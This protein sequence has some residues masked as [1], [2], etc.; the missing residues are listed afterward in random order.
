MGPAPSLLVLFVQALAA[1]GGTT[2]D[3]SHLRQVSV[4][5]PPA[6]SATALPFTLLPC[7]LLGMQ[8]PRGLRPGAAAPPADIGALLPAVLSLRSQ[9]RVLEPRLTCS[10]ARVLEPHST[11]CAHSV[12]G[13]QPL[14]AVLSLC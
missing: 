3:A 8:L 10:Q 13:A 9:A 2:R 6:T 5:A 4:R 7:S 12:Q 1:M 14:H 11:C